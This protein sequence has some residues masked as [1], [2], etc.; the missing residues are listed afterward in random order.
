MQAI[1]ALLVTGFK[2]FQLFLVRRVRSR[3]DVEAT[4]CG[5]AQ[6]SQ[7]AP[8]EVSEPLGPYLWDTG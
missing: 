2:V 4:Y 6:R 5:L 8:L 1:W 7:W 3:R